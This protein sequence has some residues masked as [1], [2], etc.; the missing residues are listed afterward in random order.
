MTLQF[1]NVH[2]DVDLASQGKRAGHFDL[3]HSDNRHAFSTIQSPLAVICGG[4][5]P[6]ALI[7]G[8]NHGDEFEGQIIARRLFETLTPEDLIGRLILAPALNMPAVQSVTRVS[9][10]DGGNLNRSFLG[11]QFAG[12]TQD[13]AGFVATHLIGNADLAIDIHSGGRLSNY[14]DTAYFCL[15]TDPAQNQQTRALSEVMGLPFTMVVPAS[16]TSGDFDS[17]AHASGCAMISCELGGEGK[18][19]TQALHRGW[20][21]VLRLLAHQGVL[22]QAAI[23]R[24]AIEPAPQTTFLDLGRDA[25]YVTARSYGLVEPLIDL[26]DTVEMAQPLA[27][28]R[29]LYTM[30]AKP[31]VF[32]SDCAGIV[33]I[34]RTSPMVA[35]GDYLCVICPILTEVQLSDQ[36]AKIAL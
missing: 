18:V 16:D 4:A 7:C 1:G 29:D 36:I 5:G 30:D 34:T 22:T 32:T 25:V 11:T 27:Q 35:P 33:S 12:P 21:A 23:D 10:L 31:K 15:S 19:S 8:G 2:S 26:G 24:L 20:H 14:V 28:L 17:A 3:S 13:I 6:T 9:P